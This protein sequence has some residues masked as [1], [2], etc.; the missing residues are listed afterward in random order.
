MIKIWALWDKGKTRY[1]AIHLYSDRNL[2][3]FYCVREPQ[4]LILTSTFLLALT[5]YI[6]QQKS[7]CDWQVQNSQIRLQKP[8]TLLKCEKDVDFCHCIQCSK[9]SQTHFRNSKIV[10]IKIL[11]IQKTIIICDISTIRSICRCEKSSHFLM[12]ST[13]KSHYVHPQ[14][15]QKSLF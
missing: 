4:L 10:L 6:E 13:K 14:Q 2:H 8:K 5:I 3:L 11:F 9:H 12:L 1:K 7:Y 15:F